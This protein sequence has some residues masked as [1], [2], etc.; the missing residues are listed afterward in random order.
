MKIWR[1]PTL[2]D[3]GFVVHVK[4]H[5]TRL[6][7]RPHI[8]NQNIDIQQKKTHMWAETKKISIIFP[9]ICAKNDM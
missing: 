1:L 7:L 4:L 9:Q 6:A 5:I 8:D 3:F 2:E